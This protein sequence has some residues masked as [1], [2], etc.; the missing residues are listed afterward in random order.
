MLLE[1]TFF[2]RVYV[3]V[4]SRLFFSPSW[5]HLL[6][7]SVW[8]RPLLTVFLR[9]CFSTAHQA[10]PAGHAAEPFPDR[11]KQP[12]LHWYETQ[13]APQAFYFIYFL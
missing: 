2:A 6:H 7:I 3:A 8:L 1:N 5:G 13:Q 10:P 12:G 4:S 11:T 9:C